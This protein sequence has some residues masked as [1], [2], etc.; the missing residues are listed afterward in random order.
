MHHKIPK[1]YRKDI[2][3]IDYSKLKG[4]GISLL[5]FDLD[6]TLAS[7]EETTVSKTVKEYLDTLKK[8]FTIVIV[9]NSNK[10]RVEPFA[11]DLK[12]DYYAFALKP[13]TKSIKKIIHKYKV[14]SK[15]IAIIGDQWMSD[16][17]LGNKMG[18][19]TILVDPIAEKDLKIT[20]INRF[21]ENRLLKKYKQEKLFE[22]GKYYE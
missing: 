12:I 11:R 7:L 8:D 14:E 19:Y 13:L 3:T 17:K 6:N 4:I 2:F 21:F 1:M 18:L 5:I 15:N 16:M 9:S 10:K 20:S 22:K